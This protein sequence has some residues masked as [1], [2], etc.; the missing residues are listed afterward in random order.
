MNTP[1]PS[2]SDSKKQISSTQTASDKNA[3]GVP[4]STVTLSP[5]GSVKVAP[6]TGERITSPLGRTLRDIWRLISSNR[7]VAVGASIITFFLLV[8]IF[9][10]MFVHQDPN[11]FVGAPLDPP[12]AAHVLGTT[13]TGQDVFVQLIVGTRNSVFWGF[14]TGLATTAVSVFIGLIAG[15]MGGAVDDILTLIINI[16]LLIPGFPLALILATLLPFRGLATVSIVLV[17]T[18]WS[19][20][21]R[22]L[23]AQTMSLRDRDFVEAARTTG[24]FPLRVIFFEVLPNEISIVAVCMMGTII[25]AIT[26][27]VGLQFLGLGKSTDV[28]WG[29][30]LY[31]AQNNDALF[32]GA[33][34]WFVPPGLC[35]ALMAAAL[36]LVNFGIDEIANPRLRSEGKRVRRRRLLEKGSIISH[37]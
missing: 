31:W 7:K 18:G 1:T 36:S 22:V 21:A 11:A 10:P 26:A 4:D 17:I 5:A 12:S 20:N 27:A 14:L 23:R 35:V 33:W 30:I 32:L 2:H 25:Y 24:E 28:S 19:F 16:F 37:G 34:W 13:Q 8:A 3:A 15:Y 29:T 6:V 9:G